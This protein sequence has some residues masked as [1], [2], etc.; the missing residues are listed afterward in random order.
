MGHFR[1]RRS[2]GNSLVRF[3]ISKTGTSLTT[4]VPGFHVNTPLVGRR[5]RRGMMTI[6]LPGTGLS[7]REPIGRGRQPSQEEG[8][9]VGAVIFIII[10][11]FVLKWLAG[12]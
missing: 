10:G 8:S 12:L 11:L 7:Y 4:G 5:R 1:F 3:N 2:F 6:G 9:F